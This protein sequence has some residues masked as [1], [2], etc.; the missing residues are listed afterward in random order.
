MYDKKKSKELQGFIKIDCDNNTSLT[1]QTHNLFKDQA[2]MKE[3]NKI[4]KKM[5]N[6]FHQAKIPLFKH[7]EM[8]GQRLDT[9][10]KSLFDS[11]WKEKYNGKA[12]MQ[13]S[14]NEKW[15]VEKDNSIVE[16]VYFVIVLLG[17]LIFPGELI[18]FND[19]EKA[20][21]IGTVI[22]YL[23][24]KQFGKTR[25]DKIL[26]KSQEQVETEK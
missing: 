16:V 22:T 20:R 1:K 25:F 13:D 10:Y 11:R 17:F 14:F 19:E 8:L 9:Q 18:G 15:S 24:F 7:Q 23:I 3:I 4:E 5:V 2:R 26:M 21:I 6:R 12:H